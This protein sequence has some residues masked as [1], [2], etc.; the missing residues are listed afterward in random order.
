MTTIMSIVITQA[1]NLGRIAN[2]LGAEFCQDF[3]TPEEQNAYERG[4]ADAEQSRLY[5]LSAELDTDL[6]KS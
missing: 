6:T 3:T 5:P 4:Y 1:Y 2:E